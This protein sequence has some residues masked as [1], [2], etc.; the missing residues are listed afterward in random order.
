MGCPIEVEDRF[1]PEVAAECLGGFD[2]TLLFEE[3]FLSIIP[4]IFVCLFWPF[5]FRQLAYRFQRIKIGRIYHVKLVGP[6]L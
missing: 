1:G 4:L 3:V 6:S 2:F 5:R